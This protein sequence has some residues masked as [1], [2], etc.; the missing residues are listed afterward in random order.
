MERL[1]PIGRDQTNNNH[2]DGITVT[3]NYIEIDKRYN[4]ETGLLAN[5]FYLSFYFP[6]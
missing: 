6:Q 1:A 3:V 2:F 5:P 4:A